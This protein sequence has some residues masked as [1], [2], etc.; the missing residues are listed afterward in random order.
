M[1]KETAEQL[2]AF[3][4]HREAAEKAL[5]DEADN[6][7]NSNTG[8]TMLG[9]QETW[10]TSGKKRRRPKDKDTLLGRKLRKMSSSV[11]EDGSAK[12]DGETPEK[13]QPGLS[14]IQK[15]PT[16]SFESELKSPS[17]E[18]PPATELKSL[19]ESMTQK[20]KPL[21]TAV[22]G[23]GGYDSDED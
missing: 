16:E 15:E 23:L 4:Q 20:T 9:D 7:T 8:A 21:P 3:R 14:K 19:P 12:V 6:Q 18:Q 13:Q 10:V 5:L 11:E 22:L 2:E 1:K 17:T